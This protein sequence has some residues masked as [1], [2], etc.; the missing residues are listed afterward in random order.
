MYTINDVCDYGFWR[1]KDHLIDA[2]PLSIRRRLPLAFTIHSCAIV[3][4]DGLDV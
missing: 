2:R 1:P 3:K 4:R